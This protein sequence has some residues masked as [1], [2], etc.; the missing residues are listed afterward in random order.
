MKKILV[1]LLLFVGAFTLVP[2]KAEAR[3]RRYYRSSDHCDYNRGYS[4][5]YRQPVYR[6]YYR[7]APVYYEQPYY[8]YYTPRRTYYSSRPSFSFTFAR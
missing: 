3:D 4:Y 5:G 2:A 8:N 1:I 7:P 6:T